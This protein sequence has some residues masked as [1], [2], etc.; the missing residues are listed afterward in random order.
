MNSGVKPFRPLIWTWEDWE[1]EY[2]VR[3]I[4]D[5]KTVVIYQKVV[6]WNKNIARKF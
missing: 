4:E 6:I 5:R 1:R 2:W 3:M